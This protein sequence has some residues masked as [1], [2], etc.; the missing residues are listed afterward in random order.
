[1]DNK[2]NKNRSGFTLMELMVTILIASFVFMGVAIVIADGV[3]GFKRMNLRVHGDV[4]NDA[5]FA[6][7]IFDKTCRQARAGSAELNKISTP[8]LRVL[9][10][11]VTPSATEEPD[12]YAE[13]YL[14]DNSKTLF[15][16]K[17][18]YDPNSGSTNYISTTKVARNVEE[19][20]FTE[21]HYKSVQMVMTLKNEDHSMT[22]ICGSVLHN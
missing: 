1:M 15:L 4:V 12:R 8:S 6:R 10:Y 18:S 16:E 19:L 3:R 9:Y 14:N 13:F 21:M 22:I 20:N 7:L 17:G 11:S 2:I 5:Y